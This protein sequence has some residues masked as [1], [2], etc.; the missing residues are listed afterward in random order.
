MLYIS[1]T[2]C[3]C[4]K[5][6]FCSDHSKLSQHFTEIQMFLP[7]QNVNKPNLNACKIMKCLWQLYQSV[8]VYRAFEE[9]KPPFIKYD[10]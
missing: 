8:Y 4:S 2:H 3:C 7:M 10:L 9:M 6:Y 5:H 1:F